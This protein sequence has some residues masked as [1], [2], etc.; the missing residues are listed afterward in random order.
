MLF[1]RLVFCFFAWLICI[2]AWALPNYEEVKQ[3]YKPSDSWLLSRDGQVV[4]QLRVNHQVR[5]LQWVPLEAMSPTMLQALIYSEDKRFYEHSGVDW[6][7]IA[8]ASW[9]NL[10]NTKTRGASTITM[11]LAGLLEQDVLH[12]GDSTKTTSRVRRSLSEKII[13][14]KDALLLDHQWQKAEILEAYLNLV[15]FRGELQGI[16]AMSFG[17]FNKAPAAL[18]AR[19]ASIA[20]VLLRSPNAKPAMVATRACYLLKQM[21]Q[22]KFCAD[23]EGYAA[24]KLVAPFEIEATNLAPHLAR[25]LIRHAGEQVRSTLDLP[26][27][28]FATQQLRANLMQLNYQNVHDGA[29]LVLDNQTGEVLAWV[30][31]SGN[32][33]M[34][35]EVDAVIAP[36]QA[37]STLK[38]FLYATA[39]QSRLLTA[40]SI[41]DDSPV[42]VNTSTGYYIPQ[43]YDKHFLGEVSVRTALG[44]SLNVPAVR[45]SLRISPDDFFSTLNRL[46]FTTLTEPVD[47]YGYSLALGAADV[48]L[49]DL[50]NAYRALS[51]QGRFSHVRL[52]ANADKSS[53]IS[54]VISPQAAYIVA[55]MLA[56]NNARVHTFGMDSALHT[57]YWSAVKTGT[58]KDMRDNWC[59]GFSRRYTVG[60]WVGNGDGMPMHDVSGV[61]G[62]APVWR[63]VMDYLHQHADGRLLQT[64]SQPMPA[65]IVRQTINFQPAI[66]PSREELFIAGTEQATIIANQNATDSIGVQSVNFAQIAYPGEGAIIALDPEIPVNEQR[67]VFKTTSKF[68]VGWHW[69]LDGKTIG[70]S[71]PVTT[72][73]PILGRHELALLSADKKVVDSVH[74]EVRG[75][76]LKNIKR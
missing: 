18:D 23:L 56:D 22:D 63:A 25:K 53:P 55:D 47:F 26:L 7:A 10:W 76:Y 38:P 42:R 34:S 6:Q 31:S 21:H 62:A 69:Q 19:E 45:T 64:Q 37:G 71:Q 4:Q 43:N 12:Q 61:T 32:L 11:Q 20:A 13:Q 1:S 52:L 3:Q 50:T 73:F 29:V 17:L 8:A 58:S 51:N 15:P 44:N 67:V 28:T 27:Q 66:E 54:T 36:R 39:L 48:R 5:R 68:S 57:R 46:N 35:P 65:N 70:S 24:L 49:L 16:N 30:G 40:A 33:S 72:W 41:L 2:D 9:R 75:A 60:V 59:V 74:F 14:S